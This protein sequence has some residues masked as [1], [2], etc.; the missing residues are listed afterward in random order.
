VTSGLR[1]REISAQIRWCHQVVMNKVILLLPDEFLLNRHIQIEA[2]LNGRIDIIMHD[3][4]AQT[5]GRVPGIK[6]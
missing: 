1:A 6:V 4:I 5:Y 2:V 3:S